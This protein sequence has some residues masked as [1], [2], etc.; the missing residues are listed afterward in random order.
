[1][2][3]KQ[4]IATPDKGQNAREL[5]RRY[6][7]GAKRV[8]LKV[9]SSLLA[10][11]PIGQPAAIADELAR[12]DERI[13]LV[14]VSSGAIALGLPA[15]GLKE[16]PDDLPR[17]QAAAAIGQRRLVQ[18]WEHAFDVHNRHIAQL[19]LT[20]GIINR[21]DRYANAQ[22]ALAALIESRIIPVINEN[23]TVAT[24]EITFGDND[25]LAALVC[26]IVNADVLLIYTD[27]NGLHDSDPAK[28]GSRIPF[29]SDIESQ[30]RPYASSDSASGLGRGGMA[31][32]VNSAAKAT[33][34]GVP[35]V[36]VPGRERNILTRT[37]DCEDV[38]TL[39]VPIC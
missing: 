8:V 22:N 9:G 4:G 2:A 33:G 24:D 19:L 14:V 30:A 17:L 26:K 1:M 5:R 6:L 21:P 11:S 13:E 28:G 20:N 27:V 18:N 12:L 29:V 23:D 25:E 31:S 36:I 37:L 16:R 34:Y 32:K 3:N 7:G 38:G 15:L 10:E 39:F 35:T